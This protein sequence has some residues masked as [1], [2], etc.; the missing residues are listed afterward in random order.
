M[1][2]SSP[3]S[4]RSPEGGCPSASGGRPRGSSARDSA[5]TIQALVE[6]PSLLAAASTCAFSASGS[7]SVIRALRSSPGA[8]ARLAL[9]ALVAD[10]H[11]VGVA[12]GEPHLDV[13]GRELG[14]ERQRRLGEHVEEPQLERR[15][16][17]R[18]ETLAGRCG[19]LV[20]ERCSRREV[21][22]DGLHV[23]FDVHVT[24]I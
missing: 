23:S 14:V 4:G 10:E 1:C 11:E 7:R 15:R 17:R 5:R 19:R 3:S 2:C 12:A 20:A 22:L 13:P 6:T 18:R 16:H 24:S 9:A 8:G 21:G